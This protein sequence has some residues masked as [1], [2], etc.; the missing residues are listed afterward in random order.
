MRCFFSSQEVRYFSESY[1]NSEVLEEAII[2]DPS[3]VKLW[4]SLAKLRLRQGKPDDAESKLSNKE[5]ALSVLSHSLEENRDSEELWI[6]YLNLVAKNTTPDELRE[7]CYQAVMY[8]GTYNV[9][10]T[11]LNL[12]CTYLGKQEIC[13]EMINFVL[14]S[15][16]TKETQSHYL[17]EIVLYVTQ[18]LINRGKIKLAVDYLASALGRT[19]FDNKVE[20]LCLEDLSNKLV[21]DDKALL[22]MCFISVKVFL[23]LP[24]VLFMSEQSDSGR[25]VN[26]NKF[27]LDWT[28]NRLAIDNEEVRS[29]FSGEFHKNSKT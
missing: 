2:K 20:K 18:L 27:V 17:L 9:W 19:V 11:C 8:A 23:E 13:T 14:D 3:S 21:V 4:L 25:L 22:W 12:E 26:K 5:H 28:Y 10:W 24:K 15:N 16:E 7:L 6:E 29:L 1:N